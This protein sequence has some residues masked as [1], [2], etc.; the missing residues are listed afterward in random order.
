MIHNDMCDEL[1]KKNSKIAKR[2][3][4]I[5]VYGRNGMVTVSYSS[6]GNK[7]HAALTGSLAGFENIYEGLYGRKA[8]LHAEERMFPHIEVNSG[9]LLGCSNNVCEGRCLPL[10]GRHCKIDLGSDK[11]Q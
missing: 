3:W 11:N 2:N 4:T 5:A 6:L 7:E 9:G 10:I 1:G 8:D